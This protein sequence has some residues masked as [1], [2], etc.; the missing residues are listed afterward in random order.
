MN[1]YQDIYDQYVVEASFLWLLRSI[2]VEQPHYN[3]D[4]ILALE[5]R[6][7]AQ[8]DGLLTALDDAWESCLT[9]L[10]LEEPGEVFTATIVAFKSHDMEKIQQVVKVGLSNK[11]A[12]KGLISALGWLP[13]KLIHPWVKKFFTSKDLNHKYLALCAC[14]IRRE[15]P[16]EYLNRI[17]ER[18]DC[19]QH[20]KLYARAL[21]I[22]GELRR[23]D[24]M[25]HLTDAIAHDNEEIK[26]WALWSAILLGH[27]QLVSQ[28]EPY[29]LTTNPNQHHA[30][31]IAFRVLPIEQ[32]REWISRLSNDKA[33]TRTVIQATGILGDPHA[34]NWLILKMKEIVNARLAAQSFTFITGIDLIKN[35]LTGEDRQHLIVQPNDLEGDDDI[36]LDEDENLPWPDYEKVSSLWMNNGNRFVTG[37]RYFLGQGLSSE[38]LQ[39]TMRNGNQRQRHAAALELALTNS[40]IPMQNM[41]ARLSV[42]GE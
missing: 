20:I 26:F 42:T 8:L 41:R 11:D 6:I 37:Q 29:V 33:Q 39:T 14:S 18:D 13:G 35:E 25:Q 38:N 27:H 21:R 40:E 22:I 30:I 23:Q 28:L 24:L 32:A 7:Q 36:S 16:S 9:A 17:L 19:K 5:N 1:A 3:S 2:A 10:E 15:N 34:V 31:N 4:E 12:E